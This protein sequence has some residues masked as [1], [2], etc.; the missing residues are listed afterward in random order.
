MCIR[1][2]PEGPALA[3][4]HPWTRSVNSIL[5]LPEDFPV[6]GLRGH[7]I[8]CEYDSRFLMRFTIQDVDGTLQGASYYFSRPNQEAGGSNFI[9]PICSAAAPDGALVIGSI[10]DSGWQGGQN[11]GGI[12]R[13]MPSETGL[14][15]GIRELTA[16]ATGFDVEFFEP[17]DATAAID[18]ASWSLQAYTREWGGGYATP[19]SGR[20]SVSTKRIEV[21]DGG[22]R[23]RL[24]VDDLKPGYLYEVS[25]VGALAKS[26]ELWPLAGHYSMKVV[27]E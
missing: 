14:P 23:V 10:W 12:T 17:I 3:I 2:R 21:L 7:G 27:P 15:N 8:G 26:E 13:L 16:T 11:N 18:E 1:D 6:A 4:P 22:K 25:I 20:H 24:Y 5:F 9:G 19:D